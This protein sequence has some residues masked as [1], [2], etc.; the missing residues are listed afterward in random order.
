MPKMKSHSGAK[1]RFNRTTSGK[2][3]HRKAGL[4]HLLIGMS[5]KRGRHLRTAKVINKE[6][7]NAKVLKTYLP[8]E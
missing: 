7:H 1:K 6:E 2:W 5:A 3:T 8:Y 4:R